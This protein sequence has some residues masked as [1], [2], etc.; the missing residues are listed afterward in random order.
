MKENAVD[1]KIPEVLEPLEIILEADE[2][3]FE[4]ESRGNC[5]NGLQIC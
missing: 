2:E 1:L 4:L 3:I 5:C